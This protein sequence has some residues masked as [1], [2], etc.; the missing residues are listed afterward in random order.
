MADELG[1]LAKEMEKA[2]KMHKE[3]GARYERLLQDAD[4]AMEKA[5]ARFDTTV[6]ELERILILKEGGSLKDATMQNGTGGS[7]AGGSGGDS[8]KKFGKLGGGLFKNKNP[9]QVRFGCRTSP[10]GARD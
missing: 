3:T 1:G 10:V 4:L 6:E 9:V 8:K 5:K 2:R 7:G